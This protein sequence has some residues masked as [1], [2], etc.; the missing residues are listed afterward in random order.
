MFFK[1]PMKF[2][3]LVNK[4]YQS[5]RNVNPHL[6]EYFGEKRLNQVTSLMIEEYKSFRLKSISN[7]SVN[8][9]LSAIKHSF[10]QAVLWGLASK[11]PCKGIKMLKETPKDRWLSYSE[12]ELILSK[13]PEWLRPIILVDINTGL[14]LSEIL[15]LTWDCIDLERRTLTVTKSKNGEVRVVPLNSQTFEVL[16]SMRGSIGKVF[17][18][19]PS[20]VSHTFRRVCREVGLKDVVFHSLRHTFAT[21]LSQLNINVFAI[22]KL[23]GHKTIAMTSRYSHHSVDSL[24]PL[25]EQLINVSMS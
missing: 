10:N 5:K 3:E 25:V 18:L 4:V 6:L 2:K 22:Q 7:A 21:R 17:D 9:E 24:K 12:E 8:R 16:N 1:R 15:N 23:M 14:R 19:G 13:S 11:N 20:Y